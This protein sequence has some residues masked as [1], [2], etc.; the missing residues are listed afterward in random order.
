MR[1]SPSLGVPPRVDALALHGHA[2]AALDRQVESELVGRGGQGGLDVA[3]LLH[4]VGR[5]VA[6]SVLVHEVGAVAR[7]L[8]AHDDRQLL[9]VDTDALAGVL[10]DVAV[11]RDD[12][13]DRL[14]DVVDLLL[15]QRVAGAAVRQRRVGD[16]QRQGLGDLPGEV[17]VGVDRQH[18][19]DLDGVG[20]VDVDDAGVGV[21][22]AH[23]RRRQGVLAQVV[24]VAAPAGHEPGVLLA[25]DG[26]AEHLGGH[27]RSLPFTD[28]VCRAAASARAS[29]PASLSFSP[30]RSVRISAARRTLL[31]MFW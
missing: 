27:A 25:L 6:G 3:V 11:G 24:E 5:D 8:D 16:Q 28:G 20:D 2:G 14:A 19:V 1:S 10:G 30:W 26:S 15:G 4:H 12:H 22:A 17:L 13:D 9:V 18:A 21:R 23:E 7:G 29:P 31:T